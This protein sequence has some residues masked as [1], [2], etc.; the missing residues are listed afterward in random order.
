MYR[1]DQ[2]TT[3]FLCGNAGSQG[4]FPR[5]VARIMGLCLKSQSA[6]IGVHET[7]SLVRDI[8]EHA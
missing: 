7:Q 3:Q 8:G 2:A 6:Y 4:R 5:Y 1:H